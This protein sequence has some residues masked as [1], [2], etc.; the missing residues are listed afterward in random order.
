M[1]GDCVRV[2][3]DVETHPAPL[4]A[5]I[6]NTYVPAVRFE[7][8]KGLEALVPLP[9]NGSIPLPVLVQLQLK[10]PVPLVIVMATDPPV[11]LPEQGF[12]IVLEICM[13]H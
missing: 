1:A 11:G 10:G 5:V 7:T 8:V 12:V 3:V 13:L 6:V 4:F 2:T 9:D